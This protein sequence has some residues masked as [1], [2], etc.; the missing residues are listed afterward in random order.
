MKYQIPEYGA[1]YLLV[2]DHH[3]R[4]R[5][6]G[7]EDV[8]QEGVPGDAVDRGGVRTVGGEVARGKLDGGQVDV[9]LLCPHQ[10]QVRVIRFEGEGARSICQGDVL[11]VW[12][13]GQRPVERNEELLR[14]PQC[15]LNDGPVYDAAVR[16]AGIEV[17]V[18]VQIV[19]SPSNLPHRLR[20]LSVGG[21]GEVGWE[22]DR[23]LGLC[24]QVVHSHAA[25]VEAGHNE[26]RV[27]GADLEAEDAARCLA[28]V[29]RVG[30]VLQA[31]QTDVADSWLVV[32]VKGP[33]AGS[34][35]V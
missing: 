11:S 24:A 14:V 12:H 15:R 23:A 8:G 28:H 27:G 5:G 9:A 10:E 13:V 19:R 31:E 3:Q 34:E 20:V 18:A 29:L 6:A 21:G 4:L 1:F 30:R 22:A 16:G 2:P 17:L 26:V 7:E 35:Q 33:V 32:E 25:V